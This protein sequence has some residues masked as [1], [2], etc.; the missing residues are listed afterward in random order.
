M[1]MKVANAEKYA[2]WDL[3]RTLGNFEN[4]ERHQTRY[5]RS[6]AT[7]FSIKT[8]IKELLNELSE[9]SFTHYVTTSATMEYAIDALNSSGLE[10]YFRGVFDRHDVAMYD[11]GKCYK[12]VIKDIGIDEGMAPGRMIVIGDLPSDIPIDVNDM[13]FIEYAGCW[14]AHSSIIKDII[15]TI[16]KESRGSF[17]YGFK[18]LYDMADKKTGRRFI[19]LPD[20]TYFELEYRESTNDGKTFNVPTI[21]S[22]ETP[23]RIF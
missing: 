9:R 3:D 7:G 20:G 10:K 19:N 23:K 6:V 4:T 18:K 5:G 13:V 14:K 1:E 17:S 22:I 12:P 16:L 11:H 15:D 21:T 8:G 2:C